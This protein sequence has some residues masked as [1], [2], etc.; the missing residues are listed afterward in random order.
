MRAAGRANPCFT[1]EAS[2][3]G[4]SRLRNLFSYSRNFLYVSKE[5]NTRHRHVYAPTV[6]GVIEA[7]WY[8][9]CY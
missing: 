2:I 4:L 6:R 9:P 3:V 5:T 7:V 8:K 1:L